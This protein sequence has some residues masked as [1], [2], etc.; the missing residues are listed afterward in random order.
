MKN[1][2]SSVVVAVSGSGASINAAK[3]AVLLARQFKCLIHGVYV[4]DTATLRQLVMSKIFVKDE[5]QEY[6]ESLETNGERYLKYV[7]EL[8][9]GKGVK[10]STSLRKGAIFAEILQ[11]A[12][13]RKADLILLGGWETG[14]Q[15]RDII[16]QTHRDILHEAKCSVLVV[17]E[18]DIERLYKQL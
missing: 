5:S 13:E 12:G 17:K 10:M 1:L 14:R 11:E 4:V 2:I 8:A 18:H 7:V 16:S 3:Y 6:E 15:D 9:E